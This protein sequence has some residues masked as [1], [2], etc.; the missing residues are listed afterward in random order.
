[1]YAFIGSVWICLNHKIKL[2]GTS[3]KMLNSTQKEQK[4]AKALRKISETK[5]N[6]F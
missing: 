2:S 6:N 3:V 4:Y 1:M 5:D